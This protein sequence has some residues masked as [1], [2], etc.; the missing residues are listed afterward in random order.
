MHYIPRHVEA[1]LMERLRSVPCVAIL[2]PRQCGKSTLASHL[3]KRFPHAI[4]LDLELPS[5]QR[6]IQEPEIFL[7]QHEGALICFDEIQRAP[8]LF[9][10]LR[11]LIDRKPKNGRFLILGS[12]SPD[13][14]RQSSE[15]LAGRISYV[16]LSPFLLTEYSRNPESVLHRFWLRGGFP[17]SL[18]AEGDR[19]SFT[20]RQDFIR[21]YAERDVLQIKQGVSSQK[22]ERLLRMCAHLSGQTLNYLKIGSSLDMSDNTV[23]HYL[24][25]LSGSF[26]LRI[27]RPYHNN[28]KKRLIKSPKIYIRDTGILHALLGIETFDH[29]LGHPEY[30]SSWES[31][32]VENIL[33]CIRPAVAA[34][35]FRTAKGEEA[36]LVLEMGQSRL[37][38]ECKA[39]A[40]PQAS[41]SLEMSVGDINPDHTWVVAPIAGSF[42]ISARITATS[43]PV[44]LKDRRVRPFLL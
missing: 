31:L 26:L 11:G 22:V 6:K 28:L 43:L 7:Q 17:R 10:V 14:I 19:A 38:I 25:L 15:S 9:T 35:F 23:R 39:S 27:L 13:L 24:D 40:A 36:D 2:G 29:L 33:S 21:S 8:E 16:D 30:G 42:P 34:S 32:I 3:L 18:L 12:A 44:L 5:E 20:W 41:R 37:L 4:Y 1:L